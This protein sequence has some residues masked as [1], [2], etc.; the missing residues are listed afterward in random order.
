MSTNS[1]IIVI[2]LHNQA[3]YCHNNG[4]Y[5]HNCA[6]LLHNSVLLFHFHAPQVP[7]FRSN[8]QNFYRAD[9]LLR[10]LVVMGLYKA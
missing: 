2:N 9:K 5:L 3:N 8:G 1:N 10:N 4:C 6:L 7:E